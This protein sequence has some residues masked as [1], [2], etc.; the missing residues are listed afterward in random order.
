[1]EDKTPYMENQTTRDLVWNSA[2]ELLN[3]P[4]PGGLRLETIRRHAGLSQSQ[5]QTV[6]RVLKTMESLGYLQRENDRGHYWYAGP[7]ARQYL[8]TCHD[9]E[10][11]VLMFEDEDGNEATDTQRF[12]MSVR[13]GHRSSHENNPIGWVRVQV[14]AEI[15]GTYDE[16]SADEKESIHEYIKNGKTAKIIASHGNKN[17]YRVIPE[18]YWANNEQGKFY[19]EFIELELAEE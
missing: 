14:P 16:F 15:E 6:R 4:S 18:V 7:R 2:L 11:F 9:G 5:E 19:P 13:I 12:R 1:M 3:S 8:R 17:E 10:P